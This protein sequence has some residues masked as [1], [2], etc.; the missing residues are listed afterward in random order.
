MPCCAMLHAMLYHAVNMF[1]WLHV[2]AI[3]AACLVAAVAGHGNILTASCVCG[4]FDLLLTILVVVIIARL[5]RQ[6]AHH[7]LCDGLTM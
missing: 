2:S 5:V 6:S 1:C 4:V 3:V 7:M